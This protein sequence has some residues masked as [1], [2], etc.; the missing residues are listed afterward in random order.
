VDR[1]LTGTKPLEQG[2]L[3][4]EYIICMDLGVI[5]EYKSEYRMSMEYGTE[6]EVEIGSE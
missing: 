5:K 6:C 3:K 2:D 4:V 1:K